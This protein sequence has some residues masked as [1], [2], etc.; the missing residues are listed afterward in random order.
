M[1]FMFETRTVIRPTRF[2]LEV[3]AAAARVLPLLAGAQEAL[4]SGAALRRENQSWIAPIRAEVLSRSNPAAISRS[5]T[6]PS[7]YS[8]PRKSR[9]ER[10]R[11]DRRPDLDLSALEDVGLLSADPAGP[12]VNRSTLN[13]FIALGGPVWRETRGACQRMLRHDNPQ[14]RDDPALRANTLVPM[15]G[16]N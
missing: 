13:G 1:A 2:A 9:P 10:R 11:R 4:Q 12:G 16:A 14:L 3:G 6:C 7:A 5:R 8:P 15:A